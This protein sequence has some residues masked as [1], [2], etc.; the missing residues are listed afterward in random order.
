MAFLVN[1]LYESALQQVYS[2]KQM[3]FSACL[4]Y[5]MQGDLF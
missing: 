2:E 3:T 5:T 1:K 4:V